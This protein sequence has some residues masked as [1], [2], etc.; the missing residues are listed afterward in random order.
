MTLLLSIL[1][2]LLMLLNEEEFCI[3][4]CYTVQVIS[5]CVQ[6]GMLSDVNA[7]ES[8]EYLDVVTHSSN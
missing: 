6:T 4:L 8:N 1:I 2:M 7:F 5:E 3:T